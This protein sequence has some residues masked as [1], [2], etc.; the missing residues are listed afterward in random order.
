MPRGLNS[1]CTIKIK[2]GIKRVRGDTFGD[3]QRSLPGCVSGLD[4]LEVRGAS[5]HPPHRALDGGMKSRAAI[6]RKGGATDAPDALPRPP[7]ALPQ[8]LEALPKILKAG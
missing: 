2:P 1:S 5:A 8:P 3:P 4:P 7:E 6:R